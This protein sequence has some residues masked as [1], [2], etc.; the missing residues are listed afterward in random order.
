MWFM[1]EINHM[2]RIKV[3]LVTGASRSIGLGV[4]VARSL[5]EQGYHVI[6]TARNS[7]QAEDQADVSLACRVLKPV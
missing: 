5:A 6:V 7:A 1:K 2:S 4:A 3:A